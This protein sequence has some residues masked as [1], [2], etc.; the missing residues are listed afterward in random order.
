MT[1]T[2]LWSSVA[3]RLEQDHVWTP[4]LYVGL[5]TPEARGP[6]GAFGGVPFLD[7]ADARLGAPSDD[8][9][10]V[11]DK[12]PDPAVLDALAP[13]EAIIFEGMTRFLA[14]QNAGT[15]PQRTGLYHDMLRMW[16]GILRRFQVDTVVAASQPHRVFDYVL[17]LICDHHRI[18]F[19]ALDKTSLEHLVYA[20][21]GV[22]DRTW[23]FREALAHMPR[24][25]VPRL[26]PT[27]MAL[28][29]GEGS[30]AE[31]RPTHSSRSGFNTEAARRRRQSLRGRIARR[32]PQE[33]TI[34]FQAL[35]LLL[36]GQLGSRL[37]TAMTFRSADGDVEA[38]GWAE[39]A[40]AWDLVRR[41]LRTV[42]AVRAAE[43]W[44]RERIESVDWDTPFIYFPANYMPERSTVP[45][46]GLFHDYGL[47]LDVLEAAVPPDWNIYLKEHPRAL[48]WPVE[49]DNPRTVRFYERLRR[50]CPRL[51]VIGW[52][53]DPFRLID[54][55][56]AVALATGTTGWEAIARGT[57]VLSFGDYW[58]QSCPGVWPI[59]S[60]EDA[61]GAIRSIAAGQRVERQ[62]VERY[63]A[64]VESLCVDLSFY[65]RDNTRARIEL[66][67]SAGGTPDWTDADVGRMSDELARGRERACRRY[68][69]DAASNRSRLASEA[70]GHN[71][72]V[73]PTP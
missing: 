23:L 20:A 17:Q 11:V 54:S 51:K 35:K 28:R 49:G 12:A 53:E 27:R 44:Y 61:E 30:Y 37:K 24:G 26:P 16:S 46:A 34:L 29:R 8:L 56:R 70:L 40:T 7:V 68:A 31:G 4:V 39:L 1:F 65:F 58:Y 3:R 62:D 21:T 73:E 63:L 33:A 57:P 18:P 13:E 2:E 45:D 15:V 48:A 41:D 9:A 67:G 22:A 72:L 64:A 36:R 19:L 47:I 10:Q 14:P 59:R 50:V 69:F 32:F 5:D 43:G 6:S 55:A 38:R 42:R 60:V 66:S 25:I 52:D 71:R